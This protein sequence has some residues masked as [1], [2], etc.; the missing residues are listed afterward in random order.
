MRT[1][2]LVRG[3]AYSGVILGMTGWLMG[4][5]GICL[6]AGTTELLAHVLWPGLAMSGILSCLFILVAEGVILRFGYNPLTL[7]L[8]MWAL[9]LSFMGLLMFIL[10]HWLAPLIDQTPALVRKLDAMGSVYRVPDIVPTLIMGAGLLMLIVL[11]GITVAH[12]NR[13]IKQ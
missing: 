12:A 1:P 13:R 9:L 8:S 11:T 5:A 10:S 6:Y 7:N 3:C 4:F 2:T